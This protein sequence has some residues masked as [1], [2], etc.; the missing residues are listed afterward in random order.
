MVWNVF[1]TAVLQTLALVEMWLGLDSISNFDD[2]N[3]DVFFCGHG[4]GMLVS[5]Q[6][7]PSSKNSLDLSWNLILASSQGT[8]ELK[9]QDCYPF[10]H[11]HG[12]GKLPSMKGNKYWRFTP[13][14]TEPWLWE[15]GHWRL[16]SR[17]AARNFCD[18]LKLPKG[19][20]WIF[21]F[22]FLF[23]K[24]NTFLLKVTDATSNPPRLDLNRN[25]KWCVKYERTEK[26][27]NQVCTGIPMSLVF[28]DTDSL[29]EDTMMVQNKFDTE[30][31]DWKMT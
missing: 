24:W 5:L 23:G 26:S 6:K 13:Y 30:W 29:I 1:A 25:W 18:P 19:K 17:I 31:D 14:S 10:S 2:R 20:R 28:E 22:S 15:E 11:T 3:L 16:L 9:T 12:S 4:S 7:N 8:C 27:E 21:R